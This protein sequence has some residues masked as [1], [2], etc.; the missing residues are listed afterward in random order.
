MEDNQFE[1]SNV[2][3]ALKTPTLSGPSNTVQYICYTEVL[4]ADVLC[5]YF[6]VF[7]RN[8]QKRPLKSAIQQVTEGTLWCS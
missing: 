1:F 6:C 8:Q 2:K 5:V 4:N 3:Q 7:T